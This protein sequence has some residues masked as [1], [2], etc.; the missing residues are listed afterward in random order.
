MHDS[1]FGLE[2]LSN[3]NKGAY[4]ISSIAIGLLLLYAMMM[5]T[6]YC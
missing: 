3:A 2:N 6:H 5:K 1:V 4:D